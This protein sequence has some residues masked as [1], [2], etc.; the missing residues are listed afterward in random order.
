MLKLASSRIF[1]NFD[2]GNLLDIEVLLF[3]GSIIDVGFASMNHSKGRK[4]NLALPA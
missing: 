3:V 2:Y 4:N 1:S